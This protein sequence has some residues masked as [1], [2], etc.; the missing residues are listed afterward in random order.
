[1][2]DYTELNPEILNENENFYEDPDELEIELNCENPDVHKLGILRI[3]YQ[4]NFEKPSLYNVFD[5]SSL[6]RHE[7]DHGYLYPFQ[8][9]GVSWL[10]KHQRCLFADDMGLGKTVQVI[11]AIED[12]L[13]SKSIS[14]VMIVAPKT[15]VGNW[16]DISNRFAPYVR[17]SACMTRGDAI[18]KT[19]SQAWI[20]NH[21]TVTSY[22]TAIRIADI[23]TDRYDLVVADE[24]HRVKHL[25]TQRSQAIRKLNSKWLW[26]LTGTP[27]ERSP[28]DFVNLLSLLEPKR[29]S[30][31]DLSKG[32]IPLR[33]RAETI[34][35]RRT[36]QDVLKE[37]PSLTVR[38]E[39]L[40][41]HDE[42]RKSYR[43][44]ER[45]MTS[46]N[47]LADFAEL[48]SICDFD[49]TT[50]Q[51][52]KLDR[53]VDLIGSILASGE[54][55]VVFSFWRGILNLAE[56]RYRASFRD[57]PIHVL[58][59][60]A[61]IKKRHQIA[62]EFEDTGGI[63]LASGKIASEGLTLTT[64]NHAIFLNQWWN[65]SQNNQAMDRIRR[66]G[67]E[68]PTYVYSFTCRETV[69]EGIRKIHLQKNFSTH[70]LIDELNRR[71]KE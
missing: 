32:M 45:R 42:Q 5:R 7:V 51:S 43:N 40:E 13:K 30:K 15:L 26:L 47:R 2:H 29:Y 10:S 1:M 33:R 70:L 41:L 69:E 67:Q 21:V 34:T 38:N 36:K 35:L 31:R 17:I 3:G 25:T 16:L 11:A 18:R 20:H 8:V 23:A 48:R 59:A 9:E 27:L 68:K 65:P 12:L 37:L 46:R 62:S 61:S 24:A 66:I 60:T 63:L 54:S 57:T 49:E 53:S 52:T 58:T 19:W 44:V 4:S 64:A 28:E 55:V 50:K 14:R 6:F 22:E 56:N 39:I 71:M